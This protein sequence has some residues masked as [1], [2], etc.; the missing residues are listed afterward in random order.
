MISSCST[1]PARQRM[2]C[3]F[4]MSCHVVLSN[5]TGFSEDHQDSMV[6]VVQEFK[7]V[8]HVTPIQLRLAVE[9]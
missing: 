2:L 3:S 6:S 8:I 7:A 5:C 9:I 4:H 1:A